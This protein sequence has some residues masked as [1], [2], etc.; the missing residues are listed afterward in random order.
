M[1]MS[2]TGNIVTPLPFPTAARR[3]LGDQQLRRNL[4]K[5]T[6]TIRDKRLR[7]VGEVPDWELL[8]VAGAAIKDA[9]LA[10]PPALLTQSEA[11]ATAAGATVHW[12]R[13]AGEA[14]A[15]VTDLVK[16]T[17]TAEVVKV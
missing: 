6:H 15:V 3:E 2:G 5:A 8:R 7:V 16:A 13:D 12:A 14:C 9:V 11:A 1:G 17:G 4:R 10:R